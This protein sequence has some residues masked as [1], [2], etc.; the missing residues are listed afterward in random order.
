MSTMRTEILFP[1][2][3]TQMLQAP[4]FRPHLRVRLSYTVTAMVIGV[5]DDFLLVPLG[6]I[7][8]TGYVYIYQTIEGV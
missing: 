3:R 5:V 6:K 1:K 4:T 2:H 7:A 8:E